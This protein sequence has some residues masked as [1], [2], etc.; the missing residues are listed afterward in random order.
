MKYD[1]AKLEAAGFKVRQ[2]AGGVLVTKPDS[3]APVLVRMQ[4]DELVL[5]LSRAA[6]HRRINAALGGA[7]PE[8][9]DWVNP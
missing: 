5:A 9:P 4:G 3:T 8:L 7:P 2:T 1:A 6:L